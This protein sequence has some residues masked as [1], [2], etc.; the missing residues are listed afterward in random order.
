MHLAHWVWM[1][2]LLSTGKTSDKQTRDKETREAALTHCSGR[3][4]CLSPAS[5]LALASHS[6]AV[7]AAVPAVMPFAAG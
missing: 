6:L 5:V 7:A 4:A 1:T 2:A 3:V